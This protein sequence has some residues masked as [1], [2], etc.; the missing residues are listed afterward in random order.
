[1]KFESEIFKKTHADFKKL[2]NYGFVLEDGKYK[3]SKKFMED[4]FKAEISV[5]KKGSLSGKIIDLMIDEEYISWRIKNNTGEFVSNVREEYKNILKDIRDKCFKKDYFITSQANRIA[6]LIIDIYHDKPEF[7]WEKAPGYGIFRNSKNQKWYALIMNIDKSKL[8]KESSSEVEIINVK[9]NEDKIPKLLKQK[10]FY[11]AYHMN[12]KNWVSIILDNTLPDEI[13]MKYIK[14]S[15]RYTE[16]SEAWIIPANPKY[17]DVISYIESLPVFSW[18]QPKNINLDDLVYIYLGAPHSA[19][20][21]K[22]KVIELDLYHEPE[23]PVMNL[24]LLKKYDP[25][26]YTFDLLK[27]YGLNSVRSARRIPDKL[28]QKLSK[29]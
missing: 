2:K 13:V 28:S 27:T 1:M 18:K 16:K 22:C 5:D 3:Y 19:I 26:E 4:N 12:K 17:F 14:E 11:L 25:K 15:H 29:Y 21:Y 9:L 10:G 20:L 23:R 8:D 24:Q 6:K 7:A